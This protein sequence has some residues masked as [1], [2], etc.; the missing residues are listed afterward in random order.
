MAFTQLPDMGED[1]EL[2]MTPMIDIVFQLIIF[3]MLTLKFKD[4]DRR[5]DSALPK[6]RGPVAT[7]NFPEDFQKVKIKVFRLNLRGEESEHQTLLKVDNTHSMSLPKGWRG[8]RTESPARVADYNRTIDQVHAVVAAKFANYTGDKSQLKGEI[9]APPPRGGSVPHGDVMKV[10]DVFLR[11]GI[12]DVV[13]EGK[14]LPLTSRERAWLAGGLG[15]PGRGSF[16]LGARPHSTGH[17]DPLED[18]M[19]RLVSPAVGEDTSL[20]LTPLIDVV[21]QLILFFLLT[22]RFT[23]VDER[24]DSALPKDR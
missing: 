19:L 3:F 18:A 14:A 13:F 1:T 21:F 10:L 11:A 17:C 15:R 7:S 9:V 4:I 5:I 23:S 16:P 2:N 22:L 8:F 6:D 24:I 12:T 20:N